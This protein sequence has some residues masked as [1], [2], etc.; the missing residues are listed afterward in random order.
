M[1]R[2]LKNSM[3]MLRSSLIF[4]L[5]C[6][7]CIEIT[8]H[9]ILEPLELPILNINSSFNDRI[10]VSSKVKK[11]H[12]LLLDNKKFLKQKPNNN[13]QSKKIKKQKINNNNNNKLN[14]QF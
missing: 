5:L 3:A 10:L 4:L 14:Y 7:P 6:Y 13:K 2:W 1:V 8:V 9:T 12:N 11:H